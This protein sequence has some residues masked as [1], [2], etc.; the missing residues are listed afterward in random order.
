M[1]NPAGTFS[2]ASGSAPGAAGGGGAATGASFC[3]ASLSGRPVRGEA[4]GG[5]C[6]ACWAAAASVDAAKK[7]PASQRPRGDE[8]PIISSSPYGGDRPCA[9]GNMGAGAIRLFR[10]IVSDTFQLLR[11]GITL[12]ITRTLR[13]RVEPQNVWRHFRKDHPESK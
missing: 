7:A 6:A 13:G 4:G 12:S 3:A 10:G 1:L 2:F 8:K 11:K 9:G 5:D